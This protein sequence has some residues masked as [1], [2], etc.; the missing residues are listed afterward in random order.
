[1]NLTSPS[2][3]K[4][5]CIENGFHPNRTLGQNF[6]IDHNILQ[7][8]IAAAGVKPGDRILE[9]G[10]GLGVLT[11]ALLGAGASVV[12]IEKD[13]RLAERLR[14]A[15]AEN[16]APVERLTV[17]ADDALDIN[18]SGR[19]AVTP[20]DGCV[21][22]LPYSVG[23]RILLELTRQPNG[24]AAITILAQQEVADRLVATEADRVNRSLAGVWVQLDY[25]VKVLRTVKAGCF[26][27]RPEID[28]AIVRLERHACPLDAAARERLYAWTRQGFDHRRK[29]LG[30]IFKGTP[31]MDSLAAVGID[32]RVRAETL[33]NAQWI[34]LVSAFSA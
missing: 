34:Q 28:S 2:A 32:P 15:L 22:N 18:W 31:V 12:A 4:A 26:W 23:T 8:I 19:L 24:P 14:P 27:P 21:S 16:H 17:V 29:Q 30:A 13:L 33:S 6:L 20:F 7:A 11:E 25:T 1:M 5:W 10:P 3:V 9:I